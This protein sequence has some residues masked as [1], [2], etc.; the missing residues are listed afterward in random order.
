MPPINSYPFYSSLL[1]PVASESIHHKASLCR[2]HNLSHRV[3]GGFSYLL[4]TLEMLQEGCLCSVPNPFYRVELAG[5]LRFTASVSVMC[6][7][8]PVCFVTQ[9]LHHSQRFGVLIDI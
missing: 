5:N 7:A 4:H 8:K 2:P 9:M 1:K 6:N 3:E